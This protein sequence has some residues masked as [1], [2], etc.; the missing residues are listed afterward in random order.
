MNSE[1]SSLAA[2]RQS[3]SERLASSLC[4]CSDGPSHVNWRHGFAVVGAG[5]H[6]AQDVVAQVV[7]NGLGCSGDGV[8]VQFV[9]DQ[10]RLYR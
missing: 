4:R 1:A 5:V 2:Y 10:G 8:C 3:D 6:V 7:L 9:T